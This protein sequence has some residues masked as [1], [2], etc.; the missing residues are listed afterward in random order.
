MNLERENEERDK[1]AV[2]GTEHRIRKKKNPIQHRLT[3]CII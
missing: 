2:N 3:L 1:P